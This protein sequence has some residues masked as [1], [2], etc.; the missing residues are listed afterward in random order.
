MLITNM[1]NWQRIGSLQRDQHYPDSE[2]RENSKLVHSSQLPTTTPKQTV[3]VP[4]I[5]TGVSRDNCSDLVKLLTGWLLQPLEP[6]SRRVR[7]KWFSQAAYVWDK[8]AWNLDFL[9]P[10]KYQ[11]KHDSPN[12]TAD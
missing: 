1:H 5:L 8:N 10:F 7:G 12:E 9:P 6:A 3:T 2:T 11:I 4:D